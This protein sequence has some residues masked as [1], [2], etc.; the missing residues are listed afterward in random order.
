MTRTKTTKSALLSAVLALTLCFTMLVGTTFAWFTDS[1]TSSGNKIVAGNL[2]VDL[3]L[4]TSETKYEEITNE[5]APIF[6]KGAIVSNDNAATLWEPGK[7]QVAYLSIKNNGSLDLKY[8]VAIEVYDVE[9]DLIKVLE[10]AITPNAEFGDVQKWEGSGIKVYEGT[11]EATADNVT[12]KAKE[13]HFFALSLH[14]LES[15]TDE[16]QDGSVTFDIKVLATQ[17]ASESDAF[18]DQYD[19]NAKNPTIVRDAT[20]LTT[21]LAEGDDVML[22]TDITVG[23]AINI[24]DGATIYG[25]G[26]T[27][28]NVQI[29][30]GDDVTF[31]DVVFDGVVDTQGSLIYSKGSIT[32]DGCTFTN[33]GWDAVQFTPV[34]GSE[35]VITN[36]VFGEGNAYR[37]IHI[38][39]ANDVAFNENN[40]LTLVL[41]NN[42]LD[43]SRKVE[44][45]TYYENQICILGIFPDNVTAKN[46]TVIYPESTIAE[47]AAWVGINTTGVNGDGGK[48]DYWD[49]N[50]IN[51]LLDFNYEVPAKVWDG[52]VVSSLE[53][54]ADGKYH[55]T[56][57]SELAYLNTLL[58]GMPEQ[59]GIKVVLDE[60]ID[61]GNKD[62]TPI[63]Y[64]DS[65]AFHGQFDG[66]GHTIKN[67]KVV[68]SKTGSDDNHNAGLFGVAKYS[69]TKI[70]NLTVENITIE[71]E[72]ERVGGIVGMMNGGTIEKCHV[73]KADLQIGEKVGGI[74]GDLVGVAMNNCTVSDSTLVSV[75]YAGALTARTRE[76]GSKVSVSNC[77]ATNC[78][79]TGATDY[80]GELVGY[81]LVKV[82]LNDSNA[83]D[84]TVIAK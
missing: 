16:Y 79:V 4:W 13:E 22:G 50:T 36:C 71:G 23:S 70:S 59:E 53:K 41:T 67:V 11:N 82:S 76:D 14:M 43:L 81:Q 39:P 8:K 83:T 58:N 21:A 47:K 33:A 54:A 68:A 72:S 63:G 46:N 32:V 9:K 77:K 31:K 29:H 3:Y 40:G 55:I 12:L 18:N 17:V 69:Y 64:L 27:M 62:W 19:A 78:S 26:K 28:K 24:K 2:D 1:V 30:A 7:T 44:G 38:Q 56:S 52:T 10:Y 66:N 34:A 75:N 25:N 15:A 45:K 49:D 61:L 5:S 65:C 48:W 35:I 20:A 42:T 51:S 73:V 80:V 84:V 37:S 57:G 60:D 6:G 74:V